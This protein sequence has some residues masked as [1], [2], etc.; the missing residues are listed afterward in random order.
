MRREPG[1]AAA[2]LS[3]AIRGVSD[4]AACRNGLQ[5]LTS[6][7]NAMTNVPQ[8]PSV[9][10]ASKS[11]VYRPKTRDPMTKVMLSLS[12]ALKTLNARLKGLG[13]PWET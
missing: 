5:R 1:C 12:I 7:L 9:N 10:A 6:R 3:H 11:H 13:R 2:G 8:G 4:P